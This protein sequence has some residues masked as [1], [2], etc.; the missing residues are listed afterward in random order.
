[1][2]APTGTPPS[3]PTGAPSVSPPQSS[4][5][6]GQLLAAL[7]AVPSAGDGAMATGASVVT[8]LTP[9]SPSPTSIVRDRVA[10]SAPGERNRASASPTAADLPRGGAGGT[11]ASGD[12]CGDTEEQRRAQC[13]VATV[14]GG[15]DI[16]QCDPVATRQGVVGARGTDSSSVSVLGAFAHTGA[17][18]TG[19]AALGLLLVAVGAVLAR[20]R[21]AREN[22]SASTR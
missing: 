1:M 20:L 9:A 15:A 18:I 6:L 17:A 16:P 4:D 8:A 5:P 22:F 2:V 7:L 19:A 12:T 11:G 13:F 10:S 3:S 21:R 14:N